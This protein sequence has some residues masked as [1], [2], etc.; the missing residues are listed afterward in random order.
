MAP[1][2]GD[3]DAP[4]NP[5]TIELRDGVLWFKHGTLDIVQLLGSPEGGYVAVSSDYLLMPFQFVE[6]DDGSITLVIAGA[7]EAPKIE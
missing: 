4:G 2:L 6:G 1:Y 5:Y 3:Y 7:I